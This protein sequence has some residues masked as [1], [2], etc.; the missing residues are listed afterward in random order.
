MDEA[1][2]NFRTYLASSGTSEAL[3]VALTNLYRMGKRP[4]NPIEF[5]RQNLPPVHEETIASLTAEL[6][7]LRKDCENLRKML[8]KEEL[9]AENAEPKMESKSEDDEDAEP[10]EEEDAKPAE[11]EQIPSENE[12]PKSEVPN[13]TESNAISAN[14][15]APEQTLTN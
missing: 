11:S 9:P 1:C 14:E 8:P 4:N 10:A 2:D 3:I 12:V 5:I 7:A 6:Q 15:T 13:P